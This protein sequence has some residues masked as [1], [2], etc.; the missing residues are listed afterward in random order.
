MLLE[1]TERLNQIVTRFLEFTRDA[2]KQ[3]DDEPRFCRVENVV[4][5]IQQL[6][7]HQLAQQNIEL[8]CSFNDPEISVKIQESHLRQILM[9]LLLNSIEA[10]GKNGWLQIEAQEE[11]D[12]IIKIIVSDSGYGIPPEI[13]G[14]V[15]DPFFTT[16]DTG[17]GLGLAIVERIIAS[18]QGTIQLAEDPSTNAR[19]EI[20]LPKADK[21]LK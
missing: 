4:N 15:F 16:K 13:A 3:Q 18:H 17:A 6:F 11:S 21:I 9:N 19:F 8:R 2:G 12:G 1:E 14:R 7:S 5:K 20:R 10:I